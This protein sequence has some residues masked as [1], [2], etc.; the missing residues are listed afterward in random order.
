MSVGST[1]T[2]AKDANSTREAKVKKNVYYI[3]KNDIKTY[4]PYYLVLFPSLN[5]SIS[6]IYS[7]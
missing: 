3:I 7:R 4:L 2:V 6:V 5:C 1:H